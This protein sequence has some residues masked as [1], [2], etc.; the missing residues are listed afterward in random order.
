MGACCTRSSRGVDDPYAAAL[1]LA[2]LHGSTVRLDAQQERLFREKTG[3][4]SMDQ[5]ESFV[6][7]SEFPFANIY[8]YHSWPPGFARSLLQILTDEQL[9]DIIRATEVDA[10][11]S[12]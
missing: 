7:G 5:L 4:A 2:R 10:R 11:I 6:L 12:R 9:Q 3:I 8:P 1:L